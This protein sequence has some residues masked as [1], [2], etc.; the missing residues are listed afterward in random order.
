M[1]VTATDLQHK[2]VT[3]SDW[4]HTQR[5][6]VGVDVNRRV[7]ERFQTHRRDLVRVDVNR[8]DFDIFLSTQ[9]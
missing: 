5:D 9:R 4:K 6:F 1:D 3:A 8:R 7:H 2:D